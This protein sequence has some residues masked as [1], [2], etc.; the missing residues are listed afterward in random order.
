MATNFSN[1]TGYQILATKIRVVTTQK[2]KFSIKDFFSKCDQI[3]RKLRIWSHLLKKSLM[4]NLIFCAVCNVCCCLDWLFSYSLAALLTVLISFHILVVSRPVLFTLKKT[5]EMLILW[6]I[7]GTQE[8]SGGS[9]FEETS[10]RIGMITAWKVSVLGVFL[11][12][13]FPHLDWILRMWENADQ[14]T[15]NTDT[16]YTVDTG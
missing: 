13:I 3:R 14:K 10:V 11:V 15:P 12:R 8:R 7:S 9:F 16:F 6:D 5:Y 2:M 1:I 4:E